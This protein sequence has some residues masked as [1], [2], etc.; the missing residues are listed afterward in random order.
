IIVLLEVFGPYW[1]IARVF[2]WLALTLLTYVAIAFFIQPNW[3][4][5]LYSTLIPTVSFEKDYITTLVAIL[6]TTIA[7][8]MFFWQT[9][10]YM[11][12]QVAR[13]RIFVWQRLGASDAELRFA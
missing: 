10:H 3:T 9:S 12:E 8:Y 6:G 7:P 11:E 4:A 5:V 2:K 13:G 1:L